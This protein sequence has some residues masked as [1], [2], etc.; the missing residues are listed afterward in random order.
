MKN[1]FSLE[2]ISKTGNIDFTF[3]FRQNEIDLLSDLWRSI[4]WNQK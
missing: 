4:L 2:Q 1:T 3:I